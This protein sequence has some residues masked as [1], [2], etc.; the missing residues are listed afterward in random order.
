ML[1]VARIGPHLA[2]IAGRMGDFGRRCRD[3]STG[4][5]IASATLGHWPLRVPTLAITNR[6]KLALLLSSMSR[7]PAAKIPRRGVVCDAVGCH[8][9]GAPRRPRRARLGHCLERC[10]LC[11]GGSPFVLRAMRLIELAQFASVSDGLC[12]DMFGR[13]FRQRPGITLPMSPSTP[14]RS[15]LESLFACSLLS[16]P[17]LVPCLPSKGKVAFATRCRFDSARSAMQDS[18]P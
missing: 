1:H 4:A 7:M 16:D 5:C 11:Q 15:H 18:Q 2:E 13:P 6:L 9:C 10:L 14:R 12:F 8:H 17:K 3:T